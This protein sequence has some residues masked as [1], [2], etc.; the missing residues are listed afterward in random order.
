MLK[1]ITYILICLV[2]LNKLIA[3]PFKTLDVVGKTVNTDLKGYLYKASNLKFTKPNELILMDKLFVKV[4]G[5][6]PNFGVDSHENWVFFQLT[7]RESQPKKLVLFLDQTFLDKAD[8]YQLNGA[9]EI[10][11]ITYS[12]NTPAEKRPFFYPNFSFVFDLAPNSSNR[13][14]LRIKSSPVNGI[15]RAILNLS[16]EV[17][18]HANFS[19]RF[20]LFG[21]LVG[22]LL[23]TFLG[24][25]ILFYFGKEKVYLIY[26][27]YILNVIIYYLCNGGY[28]NLFFADSILGS[29]EFS[30]AVLMS[31]TTLHIWFIY[32]FVHIEKNFS[33]GISLIVQL[34]MVF[35]IGLA[36]YFLLFDLPSWLPIFVRVLLFL[37]GL[38]ILTLSVWGIKQKQTP[39][40]LYSLATFPSILLIVYF[41][42]TALKIVPLYNL[43][44]S[45]VFPLTV[46]EIIV[47][48]VGLVF[49]FNNEKLDAEKRLASE[50][51]QIA[52]KIISAQEVERQRV[53]QDLHDDLGSTLSLLKYRLIESNEVFGNQLF[54]EIKIADKAVEDLS[55][56]SH[57]LT[58]TLFVQKGLV[59]ALSELTHLHKSPQIKFINSGK[60]KALDWNTEL[61][62]FRIVKELLNNSIKHS[63][64]SKIEIQLIYFDEFL[65][66]SV[67]DNGKGMSK[68]A[69]LSEGIGLKNIYLRINFL[70]GKVNQET[71]E[72]GTLI[73]IEIPYEPNPQN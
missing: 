47:F 37:V 49:R 73:S 72:R 53:A 18:F 39:T 5:Q 24:G 46:F 69:D 70:N 45:F 71:S 19:R 54:D 13:I 61:S 10:L 60:I 56:I 65:Y 42:M 52:Q 50:R 31:A 15:S 66:V 35:F 14:Y 9:G 17:S 55:I 1:A 2:F 32:D 3:Q 16:D 59:K 67:E 25:L 7:N 22:F 6:L 11:E 68:N 58:P 48:G 20:F 30:N 27:F 40:L 36:L 26:S 21:V 57:N 23:L 62:I 33:K 43:A 44:F 64:A 28:L 51:Q 12:Q 38:F 41:L 29:P 8:F 63:K 4:D 34:L